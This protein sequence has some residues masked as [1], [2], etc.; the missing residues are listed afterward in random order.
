MLK[1]T[2]MIDLSFFLSFQFV[3]YVFKA[4][5]LIFINLWPDRFIIR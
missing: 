5:L 3:I 1:S 2:D 4:V